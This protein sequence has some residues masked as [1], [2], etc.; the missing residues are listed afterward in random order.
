MAESKKLILVVGC[1][2]QC[3]NCH[4]VKL[5]T[6]CWVFFDIIIGHVEEDAC[7][8]CLREL[9]EEQLELYFGGN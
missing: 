2:R 9:Y 4:R 7:D 5:L 8:D 3:Q 1:C 6:G